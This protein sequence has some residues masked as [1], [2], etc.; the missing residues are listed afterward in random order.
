MGEAGRDRE[1]MSA[2]GSAFAHPAAVPEAAV[3]QFED[4]DIVARWCHI[5]VCGNDERGHLQPL[6]PPR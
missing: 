1:R 5:G 4:F 2:P 6:Q 3:E